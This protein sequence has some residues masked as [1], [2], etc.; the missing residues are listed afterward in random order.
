MSLSTGGN[1]EITNGTKQLTMI[2]FGET[3]IK[4]EQGWY[5]PE[6]GRRSPNTVLVLKGRA[7]PFLRFGYLLV[8]GT[9]H[10]VEVTLEGGDLRSLRFVINLDDKKYQVDLATNTALRREENGA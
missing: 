9:V 6:F 5:C 3:E 4:Q 8:L 7:E 2:P 1:I 10:Q